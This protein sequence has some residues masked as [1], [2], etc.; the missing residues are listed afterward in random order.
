MRLVSLVQLSDACQPAARELL[1]NNFSEALP[2][3]RRPNKPEEYVAKCLSLLLILHML[4]EEELLLCGTIHERVFQ[5][6][7]AENMDQNELGHC[8]E[9]NVKKK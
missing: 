3:S 4:E 5:L 7:P 2:G 9:L 1:A 8:Y 6:G